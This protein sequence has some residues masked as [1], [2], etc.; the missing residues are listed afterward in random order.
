MII[1]TLEKEM[2]IRISS[3]IELNQHYFK[4][5]KL[6]LNTYYK[7]QTRLDDSLQ[8]RFVKEED[9]ITA[10]F[11]IHTY[12]KDEGL[13]VDFTNE[14]LEIVELRNKESKRIDRKDNIDTK[15][16]VE[17]ARHYF[18]E[19]LSVRLIDYQIESAIKLIVNKGGFEFSV[20]GSGKTIIAYS[21]YGFLRARNPKLKLFIIGPKSASYAW[22]DEYRLTFNQEPSFKSLA[23]MNVLDSK[24]LLT[25]SEA[26]QS[27][28]VFTNFE[29]LISIR[30]QIHSYLSVNDVLLVV[31]EGHKVKNVN[32]KVTESLMGLSFLAKYRLVMTGTP[33]PN[34]Y[35][36]LYSLT[37]I[38]SPLIDILPY[39]YNTLL[40]LTKNDASEK[41]I[42]SLINSIKPF[43]SRISKSY[44]YKKTL[45]VPPINE[46]IYTE[47]DSLQKKIYSMINKTYDESIIGF[48]YDEKVLKVLKKAVIMRKM[49]ISANPSLLLKS[50][51]RLLM[52]DSDSEV[53]FSF[54]DMSIK[55]L[56]EFDLSFQEKFKKDSIHNE[57]LK[58]R[59]VRQTPKTTYAINMAI[60]YIRDNK[61]LIIWDIFV[62][63][64]EILFRILEEQY[65]GYTSIVN[66]S[67]KGKQREDML[68][69]FKRGKSKIL[70]ASPATLAESISLHKACQDAL[71]LN[72]NYNCAQFIQSKDR[73]H[74][75]NMPNGK[76][77]NYY[78][79]MNNDSI[80]VA[81][82]ERLRLKEN[83]MI[84]I[85]DGDDLVIGSAESFDNISGYDIDY[86]IDR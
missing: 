14:Y 59:Y 40:S 28:I 24:L 77:A 74:R 53:G 46:N 6:Y 29:K 37:K 54:D 34:G 32:A 50:I 68:D 78:F 3:S 73:I 16:I 31:D 82:H 79:L 41:D 17:E 51:R 55:A 84:E 38:Y 66:G 83:R 47:M 58:Y 5:F 62:E 48:N 75:I 36:D 39:S 42:Q 81:V 45:L 2:A 57:I 8:I 22:I 35:E 7:N 60:D 64:M 65:P 69:N 76:T 70:I 9:L 21:F 10:A 61:P 25:S 11:L 56:D 27:E 23:E 30:K 67:Y 71:Y 80:D 44:L 12:I 52:N 20:P 63:N 86:S 85:L 33:M 4:K 72:R 13:K 19:F 43:Y 49:Q 15:K 18:S 26:N 1:T